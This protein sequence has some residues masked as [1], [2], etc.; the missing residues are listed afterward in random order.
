MVVE[1]GKKNPAR[2]KGLASPGTLK[3]AIVFVLLLSTIAVAWYAV[4]R[5]SGVWAAQPPTATFSRSWYIE[6]SS[7]NASSN[8]QALGQQDAHWTVASKQCGKSSFASFT[9][10]DFGEPHTS[11]GVYGTYSVNT[12]YFWSDASIAFAAKQYILAWHS[13]ASTC[14]LKLAIGLSNHH[15]CAYDGGSC[16]ITEAGTLWAQTVNGLNTWAQTQHYGSQ[17]AVWGAFDAET[18]WDGADKTRQFV[19][20]FNAHDSAKV[21]LVDFGDMRDGSPL[22]DPDTGL[23]EQTWT[24]ADRYYVAWKAQYD[25]ALPEIYDPF[26]LQ[27][28]TS[29]QQNHHDLNFLGIMT[30]ACS[31]GGVLSITDPRVNC[32]SVFN[33][34]GF[35]PNTAYTV[36]KQN[37]QQKNPL[38][39]VT[40]MPVPY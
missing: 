18:T 27:V 14:R 23:A 17:I 11:G 4:P 35:T 16:S 21:P 39:Y 25:V 10:L 2:P 9:I 12:N 37:I 5:L 30:E 13:N 1:A 31:P 20:G 7:S 38:Y 3:G 32:G 22:V 28:W 26:D 34:Y 19:D 40:S 24:D 15:E 29:L 36:L 6:S 8:L 33:G